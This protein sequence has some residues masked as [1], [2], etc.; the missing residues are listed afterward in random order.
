MRKGEE[1]PPGDNDGAVFMSKF[2]P[3]DEQ[4]KTVLLPPDAFS[5]LEMANKCVCGWESAPD[6]AGGVN[7]APR[8]SS[9]IK[10]PYF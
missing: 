1:N 2:G 8:P 10:G 3:T 4:K 6:P 7:S 5:R 9:W